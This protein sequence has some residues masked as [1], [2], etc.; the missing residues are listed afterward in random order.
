MPLPAL[1]GP[2][3]L[4]QFRNYFS[5]TSDQS[6]SRSQP[7]QRI[8][9]THNKRR[10]PYL[11][12]DSNPRSQR[13]SERRQFMRWTARLLWPTYVTS[14]DMHIRVTYIIMLCNL[15]DRLC[16]LVVRVPGYRSRGSGFYSRRYQIF[17]EVVF[18]E[19]GPLSPVSTNEELLG[20]NSSGSGI[21]TR[22]YGRGDPLRWPRD[23]LYPQKMALTSPTWGGRSVGIIRLRANTTE[24]FM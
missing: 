15:R 20:R 16:S 10:Y 2:R 13:L 8:T 19:W 1:S 21:E 7:K 17:W 14:K 6:A 5:K 4:L 18:L 22:E 11:E 12:W 9:Q 23:T 3:P 24:F